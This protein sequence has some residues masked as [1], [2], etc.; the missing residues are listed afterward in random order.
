VPSD[1]INTA[2]PAHVRVRPAEAALGVGL[3]T[4]VVGTF[5]PWLRSGSVTRNSYATD[6]AM[7]RLLDSDGAL[8]SLLAAWPFVSLACAA[9]IALLLLGLT[10]SGAVVGLIAAG[11][12]GT[13][14]VAVLATDSHFIVRPAPAGPTVTLGGAVLAGLAVLVRHTPIHHRLTGRP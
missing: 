1:V 8:G 14:A 3:V 13:V 10:R 7:R 11:S 12:A 9:A 5:L 2:P 6:G 4:V